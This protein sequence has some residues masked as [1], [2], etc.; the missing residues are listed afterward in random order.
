M[1]VIARKLQFPPKQKVLWLF[2]LSFVLIATQNFGVSFH[3]H[4]VVHSHHHDD[5]HLLTEHHHHPTNIHLSKDLSHSH[6]DEV[7]TEFDSNQN[8]VIKKSSSPTALALLICVLLF[9][10]AV[11]VRHFL[12]KLN[13][14]LY[15][16][17][18]YY[19]LV[20]PPLR[21]PPL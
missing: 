19:S 3:I 2:L 1:N 5:E 14:Y 10:L 15:L 7:I 12:F 16:R 13:H 8:G 4:A 9:S 6:A 20:S 17:R 18:D 21:A 11:P